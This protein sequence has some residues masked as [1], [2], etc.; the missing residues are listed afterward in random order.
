MSLSKYLWKRRLSLLVA[1]ASLVLVSNCAID[2][3]KN[4]SPNALPEE[5]IST[6]IGTN[7]LTTGLQK[8]AGDFYSG[9]RSRFTSI[10]TWQVVNAG[11]R[12]QLIN[13]NL[14]AQ[15][16]SNEFNSVWLSG[17][18][19][20]KQSHDLRRAARTIQTNGL[21]SPLRLN[22]YNGIA[23]LY[24]A[25]ALGELA[26]LFGSVPIPD[27]AA[28]ADRELRF[29][30]PP[31]YTQAAVYDSVQVYL[32]QSIAAFRSGVEIVTG[33]D[34]VLGAAPDTV[35]YATRWVQIARSLKARY[36]LHAK[37]YAS[38][39]VQ[40]ELGIP[41]GAPGLFVPYNAAVVPENAQ[42]GASLALEQGQAY[43][44]DKFFMDILNNVDAATTNRGIVDTRRSTYFQLPVGQTTF[45]GFGLAPQRFP[46]ASLATAE[47]NSNAVAFLTVGSQPKNYG[48]LGT[49]FPIISASENTLI[50]AE[51]IARDI[52]VPATNALTQLN[53]MRTIGGLPAFTGTT[54]T[55]IVREI[56]R[57]KYIELFL[58]GQAYHD[59]RR[60]ATLPTPPVGQTTIPLRFIYPLNEFT[61]RPD[62][63][64]NSNALVSTL[65]GTSLGVSDN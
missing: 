26:A 22:S 8:L 40:A 43:R 3:S 58:E 30:P 28:Q 53:Q 48:G 6:L 60:T 34:I 25:L 5:E 59:M 55:A 19:V 14:Y 36:F 52:S 64:A 32:D 41:T 63:P 13:W 45:F 9:D 23:L 24:K 7:G 38:A 44:A 1:M 31:I 49:A 4:L 11:T 29:V 33:N 39:R 15:S 16:T 56:L 54:R 20:V 50:L 18:Q 21:I 46:L 17:Y 2:P 51:C 35:M 12:G 10:W 37:N 57:Q 65:V 47:I 27:E 61:R 62:M 42:W